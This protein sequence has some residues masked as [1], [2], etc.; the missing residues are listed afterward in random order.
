MKIT[1]HCTQTAVPV[2][3]AH[4]GGK[5]IDVAAPAGGRGPHGLTPGKER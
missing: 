5:V 4:G 2:L 3:K 1:F